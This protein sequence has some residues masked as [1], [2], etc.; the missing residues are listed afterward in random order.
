[1]MRI[2]AHCLVKN[3]EN[4]IAYAIRSVIDFVDQVLIFDTGSTD[5]T[6]AII[7]EL[8]REYSQKI[9]IE[10]KG[11]CD[12]KHHTE[13]R[14]EMVERTRTEW[15]MVLDGDEVWSKRVLSEAKT[16]IEKDPGVE[17]LIAP[18]YLCVGDIYH[19]SS[20]GAYTLRG[21]TA[22]A[23]PRFFKCISGMHWSG[24]YNYDALVDG[25]GNKI[26]EKQNVQIL[27]YKFWH[28]THLRRS[29]KDDEDYSSGSARKDKRRLTYFWIGHKITEPVPEVFN[30]FPAITVSALSFW[31]SVKNFFRLGMQKVL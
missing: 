18:F 9:I 12:K 15:F 13:L 14:Q 21:V 31:V 30:E 10:E 28:L 25:A 1:M 27:K 29:S 4:F 26:F 5:R 2:T 20:K 16:V 22:H 6:V 23:T 11:E 17:C 24:E 8:Q 7:K 3:E 19:Y